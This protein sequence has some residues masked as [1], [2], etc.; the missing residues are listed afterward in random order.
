[1]KQNVVM[2]LKSIWVAEHTNGKM[3]YCPWCILFSGCIHAFNAYERQNEAEKTQKKNLSLN[4]EETKNHT[5][6]D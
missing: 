3:N 5:Q 6:L 2:L 4:L 1:M